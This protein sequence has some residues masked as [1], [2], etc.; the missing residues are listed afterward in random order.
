MISVCRNEHALLVKVQ[1]GFCQ[2]KSC[3]TGLLELS[4]CICKHKGKSGPGMHFGFKVQMIKEVKLPEGWMRG[5]FMG[6]KLI[7]G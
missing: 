6:R 2:E 3:L 7:K 1:C 4:G 5:S